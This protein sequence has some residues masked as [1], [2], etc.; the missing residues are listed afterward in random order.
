MAVNGDGVPVAYLATAANV[1]D[2]LRFERLFR[3]LFAVL[4]RVRTALADKGCDAK[5]SR[6]LCRVHGTE[7]RI[8]KSGQ[9]HGSGLD[10]RRWPAEL[11]N[12][13]LLENKRLGLSYH[14]LGFV[15]ESLLQAACVSLVAPRLARKC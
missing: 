10:K 5:A 9:P 12:A 3:A 6:E 15:V 2:A 14:R 8:H 11:A 1:N 4:A 13:W 7:P